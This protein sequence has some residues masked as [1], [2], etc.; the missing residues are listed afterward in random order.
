[1]NISDLFFE[2]KEKDIN[3]SSLFE[4][5]GKN[6]FTCTFFIK[7][8]TDSIQKYGNLVTGKIYYPITQRKYFE[9][10]SGSGVTPTELLTICVDSA[11]IDHLP[12]VKRE[13]LENGI[14]ITDIFHVEILPYNKLSRYGSQ[15]TKEIPNIITIQMT[16]P[17]GPMEY[18][19][20]FIGFLS[21]FV[22]S[23]E[24]LIEEEKHEY[25]GVMLALRKGLID[26]R[27]LDRL[28]FSKEYVE[29]DSAIGLYYYETK[30]K[31]AELSAEETE[32]LADLAAIKIL[33]KLSILGKHIAKS[34]L[35]KND[36]ESEKLKLKKVSAELSK[37]KPARL[38]GITPLIY[39][40]DESFL[41]I[42]L[43]HASETQLGRNNRDKSFFPYKF[44]DLKT[45]LDK[46]LD[47][48]R[49]DWAA[50]AK[51]NPGKSFKRNGK[52]AI[53]FNGDYFAIDIDPDGRIQTFYKYEAKNRGS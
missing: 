12:D 11:L 47:R 29:N 34:G 9:G 41:H 7:D 18:E 1:M 33:K 5:A 6:D 35:T 20:L 14:P 53:Y 27:I 39:W 3:P 28:G 32:V 30:K 13:L 46:V 19:R 50:H 17:S 40:N 24:R 42:I 26:S 21:R 2:I 15:G 22:D 52:R 43:R 8:G 48:A 37:F 44:E 38:W 4:Y 16:E 51:E 49:D 25:V 10:E 45:L 36:I 23:G 31:L